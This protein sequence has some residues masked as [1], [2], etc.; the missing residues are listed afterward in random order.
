MEGKVSKNL[1]CT[2][3]PGVPIG[4][5]GKFTTNGIGVGLTT[6]RSLIKA[7]NGEIFIKST[8][9]EGTVVTFSILCNKNVTEE[10][11]QTLQS[12]I[13]DYLR[14]KFKAKEAR[15]EGQL[16]LGS[17]ADQMEFDQNSQQSDASR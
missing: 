10:E 7:L 6:A 4:Q 14:N 16:Q 15:E 2:F 11:Q 8:I 5:N 12:S 13:Y 9:G 17:L 1:F 3:N